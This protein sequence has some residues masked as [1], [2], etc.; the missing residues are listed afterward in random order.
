MKLISKFKFLALTMVIATFITS[1]TNDKVEEPTSETVNEDINQ[2]ATNQDDLKLF[3]ESIK[4]TGFKIDGGEAKSN[5]KFGFTIFAPTDAAFTAFLA[6]NGYTSLAQVPPSLLIDVL[7]NHAV[8]G[9]Y[10]AK[11]L[12]TGYL[13]TFSTAGSASLANTLSLFVNVSSGVK[14]N[15]VSSVVTADIKFG[16][17]VVHKVDKVIPL[18]TVVT[19]AT[20]NSSFTSL[21]G[22]LTA[23]GQPDFVSVLSGAGPFTVFAPTNDAFTSLNTELAPGGIAGVSSSNLTKVLQ[24]HVV[25]GNVLASTLKNDQVVTTLLTQNFT[26]KLPPASI[27][28]ANNR[29]SKIVATD[30]QCIN[31]VIH[32]LDKV[33]LP[34]L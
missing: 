6:A 5:A 8:K 9:K 33:L 27:K 19:H 15:G 10:L 11:D 18:P 20:A 31:G 4:L 22:A 13:K 17:I 24:Y 12:K 29:I 7:S 30:V 2:V 32:V 3:N 21:V 14:L 25:S 23:A 28:D 26:I 16:A 1:C 34:T